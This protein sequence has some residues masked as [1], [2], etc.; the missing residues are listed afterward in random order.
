MGN[1]QAL[2]ELKMVVKVGQIA[3]FI[4]REKCSTSQGKPCDAKSQKVILMGEFLIC[5]SLPFEPYHEIMVLL[6]LRKLI[7]QKHMRNHPVG[8]DV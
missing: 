5:I 4:T 2:T 6:V 1:M 8:L 7:L 3:N